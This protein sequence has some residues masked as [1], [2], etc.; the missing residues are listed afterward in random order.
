M[1]RRYYLRR[2]GMD[3]A[4]VIELDSGKCVVSWPT[5]VIV[6]DTLQQALGGDE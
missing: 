6:Y 4:E 5:S 1:L 2:G 3:L